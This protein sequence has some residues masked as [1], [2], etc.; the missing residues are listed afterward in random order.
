MSLAP[1]RLPIVADDKT[2]PAFAAVQARVMGLAAR[3]DAA[4]TSFGGLASAAQ[5]AASMMS[6]MGPAAIAAGII[7][8]GKAGLD[9][10][11]RIN[12]MSIRLGVSTEALSQYAYVAKMSGTDLEALGTAIRFSEKAISQAASE[13]GAGAQKFQE[14]G[15]SVANLKSMRPEAAFEAIGDAISRLP[16]AA[17]KTAASMKYFGRAGADIIPVFENGAAGVRKMREEADRLGLTLDKLDAAKAGAANDAIDKLQL[18]LAALGRTAAVSVAPALAE[19][20]NNLTRLGTIGNL[21]SNLLQESVE[22]QRKHQ[23]IMR[24][25]GAEAADAW[26]EGYRGAQ[27]ALPDWGPM[28][29]RLTGPQPLFPGMAEAAA[30]KAA[31]HAAEDQQARINAARIAVAVAGQRALQE[32][33]MAVQLGQDYAAPSGPMSGA[34]DVRFEDDPG[35]LAA[36]ESQQRY[37]DE[38][39][40]TAEEADRLA[41]QSTLTWQ[42]MDRSVSMVADQLSNNLS[43]AIMGAKVKLLD[44][45]TIA[46][47]IL[48]MAFRYAISAGV[49]AIFPGAGFAAGAAMG[50]PG[51][52][53]DGLPMGGKSMGA[54]PPPADKGPGSPI[55]LTVNVRGI[56]DPTDRLSVRRLTNVIYED[57]ARVQKHHGPTGAMALG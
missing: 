27:R 24:K 53:V 51:S 55:A 9:A 42:V 1:I 30:E 15:L 36:I 39:R 41:R 4:S 2:A 20:A 50:G 16:S 43:A 22:V 8:V 3:A 10:A 19:T 12:D 28:M 37:Q 35:Y 23:D 14:L 26:Y 45:A 47:T 32:Q 40:R 7:A 17:D 57:L 5:R 38:L 11:D 31:V 33:V 46:E 29:S 25:Q 34:T 56:L 54:I 44:L 52:G 18:S 21:V 13:S 49:N 48:S 6:A